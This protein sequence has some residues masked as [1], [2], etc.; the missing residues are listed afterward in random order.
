MMSRQCDAQFTSLVYGA[1]NT[2]VFG[3]SLPTH[4]VSIMQAR[5]R[6][7]VGFMGSVAIRQRFDFRIQ[8]LDQ[9]D[10]F[11]QDKF[12]VNLSNGARQLKDTLCDL[13]GTQGQF[14]FVSGVHGVLVLSRAARA[15]SMCSFA[16]LHRRQMQGWS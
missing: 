6:R 4:P 15:S 8:F 16:C 5:A 11:D 13:R 9:L 14:D 12:G 10:D 3:F 2:V 1:Q 7:R